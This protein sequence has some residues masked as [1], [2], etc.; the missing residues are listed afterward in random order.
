MAPIT[1]NIKHAARSMEVELDTAL[2]PKVFLDVVSAA[3]AVPVGQMKI[4]I[5]G[6]MLK[7]S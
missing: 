6:G 3:T 5:K 1:V 2:P 4:L 7:A